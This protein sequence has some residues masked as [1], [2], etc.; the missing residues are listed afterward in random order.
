[1]LDARLNAWTY[2]LLPFVAAYVRDG[3]ILDDLKSEEAR[4]ALSGGIRLLLGG[5]LLTPEEWQVAVSEAVRLHDASQP[6]IFATDLSDAKLS[7]DPDSSWQKYVTFL[8]DESKWRE[9]AI[10]TLASNTLYTLRA[11]K[12]DTPKLDPRR[13]LVVGSVQ[14]GKTANMTGL[15]A[16]AADE[17]FNLF[18]VLT[19]SLNK[20]RS[21]TEL[22]MRSELTSM[23]GGHNWFVVPQEQIP[24]NPGAPFTAVHYDGS[25]RSNHRVI[26]TLLKNTTQLNKVLAW[27]SGRVDA[28][29]IRALVIDDE[30]DHVSINTRD[31]HTQEVAAINQ[32]LRNLVFC[33]FQRH[34]HAFGGVR[35][36]NYVGYTATPYANLL[37]EAG[38]GT[39][40][41]K[42][43][44]ALLANS[45]EYFGV[46]QIFGVKSLDGFSVAESVT[47]EFPGLDILRSLDDLETDALDSLSTGEST[48]PP[49]ALKDA[50]RWFL[51]CTAALR[52]RD[53]ASRQPVSMLIHTSGLTG[54]H[55]AVANA[56][57][58][59]LA[60]AAS[61]S[62][63][64]LQACRELW[65]RERN[66]LGVA[67]FQEQYPNYAWRDALS[68]LPS[69]DEIEA[70]LRKLV[71]G[72]SALEQLDDA[73]EA[74]APEGEGVFH[75]GVHVCVDNYRGV[76]DWVKADKDGTVNKR[77]LYPEPHEVHKLS[78][79]PAYIVLGG[80]TLARGLTLQ[81]LV[82][83]YFVREAMQVDVLLQ[84]GRWFGYRRGYELYPR[85]W[86]TPL[87]QGLFERVALVEHDMHGM[88]RIYQENGLSPSAIA[89]KIRHGYLSAI[90][91]FALTAR[92][93]MQGAVTSSFEGQDLQMV[94]Y[95][96]DEQKL[97][98]NNRAVADLI[99]RFPEPVQ[100][101][102]AGVR[103]IS[104][105]T[106][107]D[108]LL[109]LESFS[110]EGLNLASH[111][112]R[113]LKRYLEANKEHFERWSLLLAG[114]GTASLSGSLKLNDVSLSLSSRGAEASTAADT[115]R[116]GTLLSPS[117]VWAEVP[118][119]SHAVDKP[120]DVRWHI[121]KQLGLEKVGMVLVYA[122]ERSMKG[123]GK[124]KPNCALP[125]DTVGLV[126]ALPPVPG[127]VASVEVNLDSFEGR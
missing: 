105:V 20:L 68:E 32:A 121:R 109:F 61:L 112:L 14:S 42:H 103:L 125:I 93:R 63:E 81:G 85:I 94:E 44:L 107:D 52:M 84:M 119:A 56:V 114:P 58:S 4:V 98:N 66:L 54:P 3:L 30:A 106:V 51:C 35:A 22:R 69:F 111:R 27:L 99:A 12:R 115:V 89:L 6:L 96:T 122:L 39:L 71:S 29:S 97:Q 5:N 45:D 108:M 82:S 100:T 34:G 46:R 64:F 40:Y 17:G 101:Q 90:T 92:N 70:E 11:L 120:K 7:E 53:P 19:G 2:K 15:M 102:V 50:V 124:A 104:G 49:E 10:A 21:Q 48:A 38:D 77:L 116:I 86:T 31:V 113:H 127:K 117:D 9:E 72:P 126:F 83:T 16:A 87:I 47:S 18:I 28:G 75:S 36:L 55:N 74:D 8:R 26:I 76:A 23:G 24:R 73:E 91:G 80:N 43:F 110:F 37:N 65:N 59:F 13:G 62:V 95:S 88:L 25:E 60:D 118:A 1:M 41:P 78:T 123:R 33:D 57:K 79:R 67:K